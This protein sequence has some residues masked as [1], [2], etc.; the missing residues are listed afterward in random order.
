[1]SDQFS[2]SDEQIYSSYLARKAVVTSE[3]PNPADLA[4]YIE[5][6]CTPSEQESIDSHLA[7]C[8]D[9]LIAIS[10]TRLLLD[11]DI[12]AAPQRVIDSAKSLVEP[13]SLETGNWSRMRI[14]LRPLAAAA[15][16]GICVLGYQAGTGIEVQ[17]LSSDQLA[18][19]LSF[20]VFET[21]EDDEQEFELLAILVK[22]NS[23]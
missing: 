10:Q 7:E 4:A 17:A 14:A 11:S 22:E 9:C 20:G 2:Q 6:R 5:N 19:E 1:M 16:I 12:E 8:S 3:C 23:Q 21:L 18:Y 13:Q 15:A